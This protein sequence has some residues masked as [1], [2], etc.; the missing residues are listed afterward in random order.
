MLDK[1]INQTIDALIKKIKDN[2][3]GSIKLSNKINTIEITNNLINENANQKTQKNYLNENQNIKNETDSNFVS[4]DSP[5]V[6]VIYLTPKPSSP[7]FAKK[8]QKIKKGDTICLIEAMKTFNEIK[9]DRDC[10]I[11]AVMVRNG[12]AVEFGQPIFEIS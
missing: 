7:P 11:K 8:G 9:S 2:N 4:I 1:K 6:G 12:E 10:T 5:M 3:L